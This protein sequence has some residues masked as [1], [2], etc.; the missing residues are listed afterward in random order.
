M[1]SRPPPIQLLVPFEAAARLGSFKLAAE[2]LCVT[3]SAVSQQVKALEHFLDDELFI[4]L[5]R[6]IELTEI[7]KA[8]YQVAQQTLEL[9]NN[10]HAAFVQQFDNPQLRVSMTLFMA[11]E[12]VL[13][14]LNGYR[15]LYPD[16][17]LRIEASIGIADLKREP[18]D[19]AMR[20][21]EEFGKDPE[22]ECHLIS[23][24]LANLVVSPELYA[25]S[26]ITEIADL[27]EQTLIHVN[28]VNQWQEVAR[29]AGV[30]KIKAKN[31]LYVDSHFAALLAAEKGLG[32]AIALFP[33]A[34]EWV[35][36]GRLVCLMEHVPIDRKF[37]FIF[38][39]NHPK[40]ASLMNFYDWIMTTAM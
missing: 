8:Y 10:K 23:N 4:R 35:Q 24:C 29:H 15:E 11:Y 17:D 7:G 34:E 39:K 28:V 25:R 32:V 31:D 3:A 16:T 26:K 38:R 19:A 18:I 6:Q 27:S 33:L 30:E 1:Y 20:L 14:R 36:S 5:V 37:Y 9:Y 2:E 13:P 21:D 22:L 12:K 40:R